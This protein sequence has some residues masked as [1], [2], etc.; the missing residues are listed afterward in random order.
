MRYYKTFTLRI[1]EDEVTNPKKN[2]FEEV[3]QVI[4][5]KTVGATLALINNLKVRRETFGIGSFVLSMEGLTTAQYMYI[6]A[7]QIV[8]ID[9]NGD[10]L[11][12]TLVANMASEFWMVFTAAT[13]T[14]TAATEMTIAYGGV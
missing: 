11:P 5:N 6:K 2:R 9:F 13:V 1:S 10:S 7:D 12:K 4:E 8:T 14:T 3:D